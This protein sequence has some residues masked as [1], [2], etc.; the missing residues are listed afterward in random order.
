MP[1]VSLRRGDVISARDERWT[2][3]RHAAYAGAT[4]VDVRG[5][6]RGN[7]GVRARFILPFEPYQRLERTGD[8]Q[9]VSARKWRHLARRALAEATP[10][11]ASLRA[12]GGAALDLLPFQLEPALALTHGLATRLLIADEVGLG[13]TVQAGLIAAETIQREVDSRVLVVAPASLREQWCAEL[14][15]RFHLTPVVI[16]AIAAASAVPGSN[17]WA[18]SQLVVTSVDYVKRAEAMRSLETLVWDLLIVD[19][20]HGLSGRSDRNAALTL[21]GERARALVLLTATPHSGDETAF[22]RLCGIGDLANRFP[23]LVF[24]RT[25]DDAGLPSQRRTTW[26]KVATSHPEAEMH[27][28]LLVYARRVWEEQRDASS[29]ARLAMLVLMRRACSSAASLARSVERRLSLLEPNGERGEQ[30]LLPLAALVA[31]DDEPAAELGVPG[32][33]D[34]TDERQYLEQIRELA[35]AAAQREGKLVALRRLLRRA[36]EPA[37]VF[38][39]YRDTLAAVEAALPRH[40]TALLHGALTAAERREVLD[41]FRSGAVDVLLATDAASEGLNLQQRCRLVINLELPW[42]PT[43]LE[44]RVG[45]VDRIGQQR[46]VHAVHLVAAGTSEET[47]VARLLRRIDRVRRVVDAM[48]PQHATERDIADCILG[49]EPMF[50]I[51]RPPQTLPPGLTTTSLRHAA[52]LEVDRALTARLLCSPAPRTNRPH[53]PFATTARRRDGGSH[54]AWRLGFADADD[55][56]IWEAVI[57]IRLE[58]GHGGSRVPAEIRR[59]ADRSRMCLLPLICD[60]QER[61]RA[62]LAAALSSSVTLATAREEAI[63]AAAERRHGCLAAALRQR[64][65]FDHRADRAGAAQDAHFQE[66]LARCRA[67]VAQLVK[68][69]QPLAGA[70]ELVFVLLRR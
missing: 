21:L 18:A 50:A 49:R 32:L 36:G 60:V 31:D 56:L 38:T 15:D 2:I 55:A 40:A 58:E 8:S 5:C 61:M 23:L 14:H 65:L 29:G 16:D 44:Q 47:T 13:K 20:A 42:T 35:A 22:A 24:R 34:F 63:I 33:S 51:S 25:R 27:R 52:M 69:T 39:E 9:V 30:L 11:Y 66:M 41:R 6:E 3:E 19:E 57:G 62:T 45:R 10:S 37:I 43:K 4:V 70:A 1:A 59:H 12:L 46:R 68:R 7:R 64:G 67:R 28:A 48:H 54:W 53:R 26:L 17:P